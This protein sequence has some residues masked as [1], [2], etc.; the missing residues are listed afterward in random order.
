MKHKSLNIWAQAIIN[1]CL[2]KEKQFKPYQRKMSLDLLLEG[3]ATIKQ[4]TNENK[5]Y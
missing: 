4:I 3:S 5:F 2:E 1:E